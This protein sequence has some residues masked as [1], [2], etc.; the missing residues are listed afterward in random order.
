M[1][2]DIPRGGSPTFPS[3]STTRSDARS[4]RRSASSPAGWWSGTRPRWRGVRR[5]RRR[6]DRPRAGPQGRHVGARGHRHREDRRE[7]LQHDAAHRPGEGRPCGRLHGAARPQRQQGRLLR[8]AHRR[9]G[10]RRGDVR[11]AR[12]PL[13]LDPRRPDPDGAAAEHRRVRE[14]PRGVRHRLL[15]ERGRC[16]PQPPGRLEH[17]ARGLSWTAAEQ[18]QAIDRIHRIGQAE[19]VCGASSRRRPS[20]PRSPS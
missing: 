12:H 16:G 5:S 15:P 20:T 14:R 11:Q 4:G 17:R 10:R 2:K 7:R 8:Q 9:D 13:L 1:A 3:S 6:R 18:T 19:P